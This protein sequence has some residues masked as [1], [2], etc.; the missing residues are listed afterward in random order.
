MDENSKARHLLYMCSTFGESKIPLVKENVKLFCIKNLGVA[1]DSSS[2]LHFRKWGSLLKSQPL[3][4]KI[5]K[6][7]YFSSILGKSKSLKIRCTS[8]A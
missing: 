2:N 7:G 1:L 6:A 3:K 8:D 5:L 4:Y